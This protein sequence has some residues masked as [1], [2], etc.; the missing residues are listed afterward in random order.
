MSQ[1]LVSI[2]E[3][4]QWFVEKGEIAMES[5]RRETLDSHIRNRLE[6]SP[7]NEGRKGASET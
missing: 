5:Q 1:A 3:K 4:G 6:E 2:C 7:D